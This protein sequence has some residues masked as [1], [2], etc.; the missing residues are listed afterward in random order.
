MIVAVT[1]TTSI[2][3]PLSK[4]EIKKV[5]DACD[6]AFKLE[7]DEKKVIEFKFSLLK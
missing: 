7:A 1:A 3:K 5:L 2:G 6:M 4:S